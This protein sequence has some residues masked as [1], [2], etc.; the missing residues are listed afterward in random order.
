MPPVFLTL[1]AGQVSGRA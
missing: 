1:F